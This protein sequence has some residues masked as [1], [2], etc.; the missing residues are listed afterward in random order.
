MLLF[1]L[2]Q[3]ILF[4]ILA[5]GMMCFVCLGHGIYAQIL[6][7]PWQG[8]E[9]GFLPW[10][11][12]NIVPQKYQIFKLDIESFKKR[13]APLDARSI[14]S[15]ISS[16][17]VLELP[18]PDGSL[19][20]FKVSE[21]SMMAPTL[22]DQFPNIKTYDIVGVDDGARGKLDWTSWGLHG[23][24]R[25]V[26]GDFFIDPYALGDSVHYISY[27]TS[28]FVKESQNLFDEKIFHPVSNVKKYLA[29]AVGRSENA[30]SGVALRIYRLAI[31]CTGEYAKAVTGLTRPTLEQVF[32]SVLTSINRVNGVYE[33][34]LGIKLVLVAKETSVLFTDPASD[35]YPG[36]PDMWAIYDLSQGILDQY[37][38]NKEYDIGHTLHNQG[39]G[40]ASM[41]SVCKREAKGR[42]ATGLK[43]PKGDPF[44]I[45]YLCHEIGHQ[46]GA[47]HTFSVSSA[48]C[49]GNIHEGTRVEP[50][51]GVSIMSY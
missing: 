2:S 19:Q 45:D 44:D 14:Y 13:L 24:V 15:T 30:C 41:S 5:V 33:S 51:G 11:E 50:A 17:V 21:S 6:K 31:A 43:A 7:S 23:M 46:F 25:S 38:G 27:F 36:S 28:D 4:R 49:D 22:A 29:G 1:W 3:K 47:T 32:S 8:I 34:K 42:V 37:I 20:P 10:G 39:G 12:M 9:K 26:N 18:M 16:E 35:P 40:L 48:A